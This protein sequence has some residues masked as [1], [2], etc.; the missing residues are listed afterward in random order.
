MPTR[1]PFKFRLY[2]AG[3][4]PNSVRAAANLEALRAELL[5]RRSLVEVVDV[6][7]EPDRALADGIML[8]PA[9]RRLAPAP[10]RTVV[11][12]LGER[13]KVIQALGLPMNP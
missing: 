12:T 10:V 4:S 13:A 1:R 7:R 6:L 11:G 2:L 8:T 3:D 9:V 5:P